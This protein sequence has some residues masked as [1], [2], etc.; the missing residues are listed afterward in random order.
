MTVK[1]EMTFTTRLSEFE[2]KNGYYHEDLSSRIS[3]NL[4]FGVFRPLSTILPRT[5]LN[6]LKS[7]TPE[8]SQKHG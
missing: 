1:R 6:P 3:I 4:K 2:T 8:K 7:E 5:P